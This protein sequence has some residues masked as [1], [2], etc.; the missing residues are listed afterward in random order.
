MKKTTKKPLAK[1]SEAKLPAWERGMNAEQLE[2]INHGEGPLRLLAA[3]GSG[4]T[5]VVVHRIMRLVYGAG[6][7]AS[8]ILAVTFSKK[9]ALE[10]NERLAQLGCEGARVGTWHSLC[11]QI[12]KED[13]TEEG[14]WTIEDSGR[15]TSTK[16]ILKEVLG[17]REMNW[18]GADFN[19]IKSF[20]GKCKANLFDPDSQGAK[21]LAAQLFRHNAARA[22]EA[23]DR[24]NHK[25]REK[26]LLTFDDYLVFV[27]KH[28][29]IEENRRAWASK[30]DYVIQDEAQDANFAQ[31]TIA[32]LL[33][34]DHGNY[35]AV[36]DVFQAIYAF[37][38]SSP[39][40][41]ADF[42]TEWPGAKTI[43]LGRNYRSGRK[44]IDAAN[45][46]VRPARVPGYEPRD[47]IA[48]R[49]FDGSAVAHVSEDLDGEAVSFVT[50][51]KE[52]TKT[53]ENTHGDITALFRTNAQSRALEEQLLGAR[54]PYVVVGGISF[55]ERTEVRALL[56]Y[57]RVA[58]ECG[59]IEDI[60][61]CINAPFRFLG[62]AFVDRVMAAAE[63]EA[64]GDGIDW[65]KLVGEVA[66]QA[67]LQS[68][69]RSSA[70]EWCRLIEDAVQRIHAGAV[71]DA[72]P[73]AK[74]RA[75]P[76]V[77][78]ED[79]VR[80][81]RFIDWLTKEEGEDSI[82]SSGAA[83]IR[84]MIRVAERFPTVRELIKYIDDT[85]RSAKKQR[86]GGQAGGDRVLLM[87]I[88]KSKGLEW[89]HVWVSG[90]NEMILPHARGDA[91]EER[92]IAYVAAT[93]ARD[94]LVLSYVRTLA[95]RAGVKDAE[96][97]RFLLD[98][99][100]VIEDA[101]ATESVGPGMMIGESAALP[102]LPPL[103]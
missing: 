24:Y 25:I 91:E 99:G 54:I 87:S 29:S 42:E 82:E 34:M 69:Q 35:M 62:L 92:R 40:Y 1:R 53:G 49:D 45:G 81:T 65:T 4:K 13:Q 79:I 12:L 71:D 44:I 73:D 15:G 101:E 46:I 39:V 30:W 78:L 94:T 28:L 11:L 97:S 96:P 64:G 18:T 60:K 41:L 76:A 19:A 26:R 75:R 38:G 70:I 85:I 61:R 51:V 23:F 63:Q 55:Y 59:E 14:S 84:E 5:R 6:V 74:N 16:P 32:K 22:C 95:T 33:A 2:A 9:A 88:H 67:G 37:R 86:E 89:P 17:F 66:Q 58:A 68:R 103:P 56:A 80:A 31:K 98:T 7:E 90:F 72:T 50:W 77:I 93:R 10:M 48:S 36:G 83:N 20:I 57:L 47:M 43:W 21:D 27:A 3:A 100:L 102:E 8:R 52:L